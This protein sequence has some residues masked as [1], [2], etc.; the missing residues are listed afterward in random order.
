M[1]V[2]HQLVKLFLSIKL[3]F[4]FLK[5][6]DKE[7]NSPEA[8]INNRLLPQLNISFFYSSQDTI[9]KPPV[10]GK[11]GGEANINLS[12]YLYLLAKP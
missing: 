3:P 5:C 11:N 9:S 4:A 10:P 12:S 1:T 7:M 2:R 8:S 6:I